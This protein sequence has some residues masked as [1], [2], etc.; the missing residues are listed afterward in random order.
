MLETKIKEV[1]SDDRFPALYSS[2][3]REQVIWVRRKS[4]QGKLEGICVHPKQSF[5]EYSV[6]WSETK[7]TKMGTG[8][9]LNIKFI[10]E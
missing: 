7:Y 4:A 10:Q 3:N 6:T 9:E 5:G 8:S 1:N 2:E